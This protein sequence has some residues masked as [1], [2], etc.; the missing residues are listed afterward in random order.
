MHC[1]FATLRIQTCNNQS[2]PILKAIIALSTYTTGLQTVYGSL[3]DTYLLVAPPTKKTFT[4]LGWKPLLYAQL[5]LECFL[6]SRDL[7]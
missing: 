2:T 6:C 3:P 5:M 1:V 4:A 7:S